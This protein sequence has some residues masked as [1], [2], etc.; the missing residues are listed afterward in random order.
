MSDKESYT[1]Y[2]KNTNNPIIIKIT[3]FKKSEC[4]A[5]ERA[6][7]VKVRTSVTNAESTPERCSL[8]YTQIQTHPDMVG[9]R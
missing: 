9:G 6:L 7:Q 5:G 3:P 4:G 1:E 2:V 8:I